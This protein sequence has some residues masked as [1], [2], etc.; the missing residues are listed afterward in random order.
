MDKFFFILFVF[1]LIVLGDPDTDV[2]DVT[3]RFVFLIFPEL[4]LS[5]LSFFTLG[6]PTISLQIEM[7]KVKASYRLCLCKG[8][9][10]VLCPCEVDIRKMLILF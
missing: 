6:A 9:S 1:V 3:K 5:F 10:I 7:K 8:T 2:L 4:L